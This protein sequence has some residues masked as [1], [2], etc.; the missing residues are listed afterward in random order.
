[1]TARLADLTTLKLGGPAGRFVTATTAD[2]VVEAVR[3]ADKVGE[4]LLVLAGGSNVVVADDGFP[5]TVLHVATR[6]I[7]RTDT[8]DRAILTAQAGEPWDPFVARCVAEGLAGVEALSGI[9][10]SVGATPI[11]NVGAYGQEVAETIAAVTVLDRETATVE[12]L[13]PGACGFAYR[14]SVFKRTPGRWVVLAVTFALTPDGLSLPIRYAELARAL[15]VEIGDRAPLTAVRD[16]VLALRRRKG[17]VV[18]DGD[19]D[20]V[21]AGSFFT[22][23]IL[24]AEAF[25]DLLARARAKLGPDAIPPSWPES[26][27]RVK[28]SA[29]WLIE[30]AGF[31]KGHGDPATVAISGKHTLALTNRG[32]GTAALLVALAR[33]VADGVRREFGVDLVPEPVFVGHAWAQD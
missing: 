30:R 1:V 26:D 31:T 24:D 13:D 20:S 19:P 25:A 23:P 32:A 33:E 17:M 9:P 7:E 14:S 12:A 2:Q 15:G 21:S 8:G 22:N 16:A 4:P 28:T 3:S 27:G 6:G 10:G 29:A 5:G 11:Q 18:D